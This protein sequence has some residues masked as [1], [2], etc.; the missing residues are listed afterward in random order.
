MQ[1][2]LDAPV[3]AC[4]FGEGLGGGYALAADIEG[5]LGRCLAVD[6]PASFDHAD[7]GELG[8]MLPQRL[9][10]PRQI[11]D[12]Q[13][14]AGFNTTVILFDGL[15][16]ADRQAAKASAPPFGE[17]FPQSIGQGFL[18][19]LDGQEV[20]AAS[21]ENFLGDLGLAADSVNRDNAPLD[22]G[23]LVTFVAG[24]R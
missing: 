17:E 21:V 11:G 14:L 4:C 5:P 18:V 15:V 12:P 16:A 6:F 19:V 9:V 22:G 2:V 20:V 7:P 23:N 1:A 13:R 8:P 24:M 3:T 10:Q